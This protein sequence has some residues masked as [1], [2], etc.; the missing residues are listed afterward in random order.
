M[1]L[2]PLTDHRISVIHKNVPNILSAITSAVSGVGLN[3][4]NLVNR[5][6]GQMA[7]TVLDTETPIPADVV[8]AIEA[9]ADILKVRVIR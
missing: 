9:K 6:R 4:E 3:I 8:K 5:S 2:P 7:C 1:D